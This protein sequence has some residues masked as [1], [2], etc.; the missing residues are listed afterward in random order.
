VVLFHANFEDILP[1]LRDAS[2][3][4]L[5]TD[6]PYG[7]TN[8]AWDKTVNWPLFWTAAHR[9]CKPKSPI[10]LFACGKF[11]NKLINT[12][13]SHYRYDLV[14]EKNLAVG[15]LDANRKPLRS[16]E[17]ILVFAHQFRG[18]TYNPQ[19]TVGKSHVRS[20]GI[21]RAVHYSMPKRSLPDVVTNLY[22]PRSILKFN[23]TRAGGKSLH[24]TQK[25]LDLMKWLVR[26]Y[27]NRNEII[28]DP[29]SGSGSTLIAAAADGRR[30]I[31]VEQNEEYC[32]TIA[33]RLESGN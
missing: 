26:T 7:N 16:H 19:M 32:E 24:P 1:E 15:F 3:D 8:I 4:T 25:P 5:I 10:V 12:N 18:S 29:F 31:G 33:T 20:G 30:A 23:N 11:V 22:H 21:S 17:S 27:S 14:W 6:P 9:I 2:I 13:P 28:L